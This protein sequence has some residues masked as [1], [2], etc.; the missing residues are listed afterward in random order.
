MLKIKRKKQELKK[1]KSPFT[2][3]KKIPMKGF[4]KLVTSKLNWSLKKL[5]LCI[6]NIVQLFFL[7]FQA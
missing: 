1:D 3:K 2:I 4:E 7:S 5:F 6:Q